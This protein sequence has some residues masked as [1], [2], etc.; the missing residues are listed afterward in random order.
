[1]EKPN[2]VPGVPVAQRYQAAW[3][4]INARLQ[5]RQNLGA[6]YMTATVAMLGASFASPSAGSDGVVW[7]MPFVIVLPFFSFAVARWVRHNDAIIGLLNSYCASLEEVE[8]FPEVPA[9][10]HPQ[11][12]FIRAALEY[13]LWTDQAVAL[14]ATVSLLPA[15]VHLSVLLGL[16]IGAIF[17]ALAIFSIPANL[18]LP[19]T[20]QGGA[21]LA[22][23]ASVGAGVWSL[24]II[25]NNA[26]VRADI[27]DNHRFVR[28]GAESGFKRT[29]P[30]DVPT[31]R[32]R[33]RR[34]WALI[35]RLSP[36]PLAP[37]ADVKPQTQAE[38]PEPPQDG[39]AA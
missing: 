35:P 22:T 6:V 8:D 38:R 34:L 9:W 27:K 31:L 18:G 5:S 15:L 7:R 10:Q 1:M 16:F 3:A 4:E 33:A 26:S 2:P 30:A 11:H 19:N 24:A 14:I 23:V 25:A 36:T 13:R 17:P 37:A 28:A 20:A 39:S 29:G 32:V 21:L 12:G